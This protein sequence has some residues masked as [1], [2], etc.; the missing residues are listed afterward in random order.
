MLVKK[1][2]YIVYVSPNL[3]SNAATLGHEQRF[4]QTMRDLAHPV[5][6][7]FLGQIPSLDG[8]LGYI[9]D[10]SSKVLLLLDDL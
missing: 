7:D 3:A 10:E 2:T 5:S 1:Y 4:L 8:I 9:Q 6:I